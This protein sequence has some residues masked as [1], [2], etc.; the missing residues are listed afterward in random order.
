MAS[1]KDSY[2]K[3]EISKK[4]ARK[5]DRT[6]ISDRDFDTKKLSVSAERLEKARGGKLGTG[7]GGYTNVKKYSSVKPK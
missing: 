2:E 1:I 3:S 7:I 4:V 5:I 6:P